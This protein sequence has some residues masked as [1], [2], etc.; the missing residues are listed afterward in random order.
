MKTLIRYL[1]TALLVATPILVQGAT[2]D[3]DV[4]HSNLQFKVKHLMITNVKG[5][6]N[7]FAGTLTTDGDDLSTGKLDVTIQ[8]ATLNTD[9][10]QRDD[11]LRSPD[12]FDAARYPTITFVSKNFVT[13]G[14]QVKQI[15][16]DLTIHGVTREVVLEVEEQ[17]PIVTGP[18]GKT[19]RGATA[20][21]TVDRFD[22]GLQWNKLMETGGVVVGNDVK[23]T[24]EVELIKR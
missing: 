8:T 19:R 20:T 9:N 18:W 2:W 17:S 10:Q 16:G 22:Y 12:F 15:V 6:F 3:L 24:L 13:E 5:K 21:T 4:D 14:D 23:I 7:S 11:H 1:L